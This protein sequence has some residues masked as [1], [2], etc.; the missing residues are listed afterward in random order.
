ML[1]SL[2]TCG[3]ES[4]LSERHQP[5]WWQCSPVFSL[6]IAFDFRFFIF[7]LHPF[8]GT[9]VE[10]VLR[11]AA[12]LPGTALMGSLCSLCGSRDARSTC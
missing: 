6:T 1:P 4:T 7:Y 12:A 3:G 8:D 5:L 2:I 10:W 11:E 9:A